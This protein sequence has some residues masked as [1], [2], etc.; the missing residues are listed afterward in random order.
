MPYFG[1]LKSIYTIH[2][3]VIKYSIMVES[4]KS[5]EHRIDDSSCTFLF[6][7]VRVTSNSFDNDCEGNNESYAPVFSC[8][9]IVSNSS[10]KAE[11]KGADAKCKV[12]VKGGGGDGE[13][14]DNNGRRVNE[15]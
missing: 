9:R 11:R 1:L 10:S 7:S 5:V 6:S 2:S 4:D 13:S 12:M 8:M 15:V 14:D 3:S